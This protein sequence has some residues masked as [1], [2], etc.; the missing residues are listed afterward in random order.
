MTIKS[1]KAGRSRD[2]KDLESSQ[3]T[4]LW[5]FCCKTRHDKTRQDR[6]GQDK[7]RQDKTRQDKTRQDKTRQTSDESVLNV[8][9][10]L[11]SLVLPCLAQSCL[12]FSW[13]EYLIL[14][15][16]AL[17]CFILR[18]WSC[19]IGCLVLS[20]LSWLGLYFGFLVIVVVSSSFVLT[21]LCC[22]VSCIQKYD[23]RR[24]K[25]WDKR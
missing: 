4:W 7:T 8:L 1:S 15:C 10:W 3:A 24:D 12:G 17:S 14:S 22:L 21:C 16:L 13:L 19:L 18:R 5:I 25:R 20:Y 23:E 2:D 9:T 11:S 6:T